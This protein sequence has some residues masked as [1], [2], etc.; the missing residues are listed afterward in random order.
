MSGP[1]SRSGG[2]HSVAIKSEGFGVTDGD[3]DFFANLLCAPMA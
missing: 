2:R 1:L 3:L